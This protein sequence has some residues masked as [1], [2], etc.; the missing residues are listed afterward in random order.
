MAVPLRRIQLQRSPSYFG[1][2]ELAGMKKFLPSEKFLEDEDIDV[3]LAFGSSSIFLFWAS[4]C[5]Q[6]SGIPLFALK[7]VIP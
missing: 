4:I 2:Q 6:G 5:L 7:G 1:H 3:F